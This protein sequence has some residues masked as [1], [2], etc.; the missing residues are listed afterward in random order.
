MSKLSKRQEFIAQIEH[1]IL[2]K[3]LSIGDRLPTE[4]ELVTRFD[5]SRTVV[6]AS[7]KE[8]AQKGFLKIVPRKWTE[9]ADYK[10]QGTLAVLE[11]IMDFNG[12]NLDINLLDGVLE[13]RLI[14]ETKSVELA[15]IKNNANDIEILRDIN[16]KELSD[17]DLETTV[18]LDF[19]FHH[20]IAVISQ[21]PVYPLVLKSFEAMSR[22]FIKMFYSN[23]TDKELVS[24]YHKKII[25]YIENR[26][27][28]NAVE[29]TKA[30]LE[31]GRNKIFEIIGGELYE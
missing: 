16:S 20:T 28:V 18:A 26:D 8:L 31:H 29:T 4:R 30:M 22:K 7:I 17:N 19:D 15:C 2:S 21:N 27:V 10:R 14:I 9:V 12:D 11:A 5:T 6:N 23:L 13:T 1:M 24:I 3:E 25:D